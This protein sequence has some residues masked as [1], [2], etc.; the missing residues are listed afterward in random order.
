[1]DRVLT[2]RDELRKRDDMVR[3]V[4]EQLEQMDGIIKMVQSSISKA[5]EDAASA[6]SSGV[7]VSDVGTN[8][9]GGNRL[10]ERRQ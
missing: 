9:S 8:R 4:K 10:L 6:A 1:M 3:S 5:A 2:R 7:S